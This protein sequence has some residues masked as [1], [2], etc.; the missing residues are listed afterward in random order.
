MHST[1]SCQP[2]STI[3]HSTARVCGR[4]QESDEFDN[5]SLGLQWQ[6]HANYDERWGMPTADGHMRLYTADVPD[7][8]K[9]L[10]DMPNLLLQ[11]TPCDRFT[12][13]TK[14]TF[15]SKEDHQYGGIV[16]MGRNYSALVVNRQG[17]GFTLERHTCIGADAARE[18]QVAT[19]ATLRPTRRDTIPYSPAIYLDVYLRM[20][21][22]GNTCR[23]QYSLDGKRFK[24][25]GEAFNIKQGKWI[26]AKMGYVA[27]CRGRKSN[28][29]WI[30]ADWWRVSLP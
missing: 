10:W 22:E 4:P 1:N 20:S 26:G 7:D 23:F 11:K 28:R 3:S 27:A 18:E 15:A 19:L 17:D 29:G 2:T 24:P 14:I 16:M 21:V 9:S 8:A 6:W 25:A 13:T 12:A 30:D 5:R